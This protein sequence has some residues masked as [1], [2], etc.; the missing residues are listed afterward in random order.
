MECLLKPEI[1]LSF[2]L[3]LPCTYHW[4]QGKENLTLNCQRGPGCR[5]DVTYKLFSFFYRIIVVYILDFFLIT[6]RQP[7]IQRTAARNCIRVA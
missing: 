6:N 1:R 5:C 4:L 7:L 2:G 3:L